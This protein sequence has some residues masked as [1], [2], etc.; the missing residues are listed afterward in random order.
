[1]GTKGRQG[2]HGREL[3]STQLKDITRWNGFLKSDAGICSQG[4]RKALNR[5]HRVNMSKVE[6]VAQRSKLKW[7]GEKETTI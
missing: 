1:V 6:K 3:P 5:E 2:G 4:E 7:D